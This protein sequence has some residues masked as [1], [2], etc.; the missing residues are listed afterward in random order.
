MC[1]WHLYSKSRQLTKYRCITTLCGYYN[2]VYNIETHI[3][4]NQN[5]LFFTFEVACGVVEVTIGNY[6]SGFAWSSWK[7]LVSFL[8]VLAEFNRNK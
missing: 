8:I 4:V 7:R 6:G 5:L 3:F 1:K 2:T